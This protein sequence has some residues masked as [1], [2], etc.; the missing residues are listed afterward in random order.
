LSIL[1]VEKL[2]NAI[3]AES[4]WHAE[5]SF[6]IRSAPSSARARE[7]S[8][9]DLRRLP[10][11]LPNQVGAATSRP[12]ALSTRT[13]S[14]RGAAPT[15]R[16][17]K[18]EPAEKITVESKWRAVR[19]NRSLYQHLAHGVAVVVARV[20]NLPECG[21]GQRTL[22]VLSTTHAIPC[23]SPFAPGMQ[24]R[25]SGPTGPSRL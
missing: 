12:P 17:S 22:R 19:Q 1:F 9:R 10:Q 16:N 3:T 11:S 13:E 6:V 23:M 5:P 7:A 14:F 4:S 20:E 8:L 2:K 18:T 21:R 15:R 25:L 24:S